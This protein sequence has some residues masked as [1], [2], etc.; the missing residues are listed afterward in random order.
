MTTMRKSGDRG[1]RM[2]LSQEDTPGPRRAAILT[3][4][5]V[6]DH[7]LFGIRMEETGAGFWLATWAFAIP[8]E[9]AAREGYTETPLWTA[10][11]R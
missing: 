9:R 7:S 10:P 4:R 3:V 8:P 2:T 11:F 1:D 5:C 6:H